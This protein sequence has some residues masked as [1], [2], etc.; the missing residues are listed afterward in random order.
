MSLNFPDVPCLPGR[1]TSSVIGLV[2]YGQGGSLGAV[3][4]TCMSMEF[5]AEGLFALEVLAAV[6]YLGLILVCEGGE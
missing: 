3:S 2:L 1:K 6:W 4:V 5:R